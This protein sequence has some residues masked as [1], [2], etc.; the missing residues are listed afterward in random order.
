ME[1][2][3][4]RQ[5]VKKP[6]ISIFI[7]LSCSV[8]LP[9]CISVNLP[10]N[11]TVKAQKVSFTAPSSPYQILKSTEVDQAWQSPQNG[12]T[13]A[14]F[15]ECNT[16]IETSL[17]SLAEENFSALTEAKVQKVEKKNTGEI[18]SIEA[19]AEGQ[20]DGTKMNLALLIF[21]KNKC[22]YV[23]SFM[24]KPKNFN[25]DFNIFEK[26]KGDFRAP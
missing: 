13:I 9:A 3:P 24:A 17:D 1:F 4:V 14:Y 5:H 19:M 23:L 26:F 12:N 11:N 25:Q 10:S 21:K 6:L 18:D 2:Q 16:N 22:S 15:S 7:M 20:V 8:L